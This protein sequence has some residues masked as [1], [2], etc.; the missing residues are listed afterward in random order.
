M[1]LQ[2][3]VS[4]PQCRRKFLLKLFG[5]Q[6][7]FFCRSIQ[8]RCKLCKVKIAFDLCLVMIRSK[9]KF[10]VLDFWL[11]FGILKFSLVLIN[12]PKLNKRYWTKNMKIETNVYSVRRFGS[13]V[14]FGTGGVRCDHG[15]GP[16]WVM[17]SFSC[18]VQAGFNYLGFQT[19]P[20]SKSRRG[21]QQFRAAGGPSR[22]QL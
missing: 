20:E 4:C 19:H 11:N 22:P 9:K 10:T 18:A 2:L 5:K 21:N 14:R 13:S 6:L 3:S 12:N 1:V 15:I 8:L 17:E 16:V 7:P